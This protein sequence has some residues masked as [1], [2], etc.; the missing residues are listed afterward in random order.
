LNRQ[1]LLCVQLLAHSRR[2]LSS[3]SS[4]VQ[5]PDVNVAYA[6]QRQQHRH[7]Q[8]LQSRRLHFPA[9]FGWAVIGQPS[10]GFSKQL[11][12]AGVNG[13]QSVFAADVNNDG[14]I[15][16]SS[17]GLCAL[18]RTPG[19]PIIVPD[20]TQCKQYPCRGYVLC[21][22]ENRCGQ[23]WQRERRVRSQVKRS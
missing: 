8:L 20:A 2:T 14:F 9:H 18:C 19:H 22:S 23:R 3:S 15:G 11:I 13:A 10:P 1:A 4:A 17:W 16:P 5:P 21:A 7:H 6:E 12:F